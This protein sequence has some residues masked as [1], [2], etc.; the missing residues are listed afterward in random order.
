M[1][2][3]DVKIKLIPFAEPRQ[4]VIVVIVPDLFA[5]KLVRFNDMGV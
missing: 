4:I 1:G 2:R 3:I 5:Q